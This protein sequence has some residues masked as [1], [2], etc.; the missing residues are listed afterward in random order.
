[1][2]ILKNNKNSKNNKNNEHPVITAPATGRQSS[3]AF[4]IFAAESSSLREESRIYYSL[5]QQ[6]PVIDAAITK[7]VRLTG[8]FGI[9]CD[10]SSWDKECDSLLKSIPVNGVSKGIYA[11]TDAFFEQL[12]TVGTA[13]GEIVTD[14]HGHP[15][16]LFNSPV[17][18]V[19]FKRAEN[20]FDVDI[21]VEDGVKETRAQNK[22]RILLGVL[23]PVPGKIT[24]QSLLKGL[25]FVSSILLKIY[26]TIG[27]NWERAGAVRYAVTYKPGA[28]PQ[29]KS[30]AGERAKQIAKS[31]G[32]AMKSGGD[33]KDFV[34]VGDVQIKVIGSDSAIL[35]PKVPVQQMLE[36]IIAKTGL[37]PFMLGFSWSTTERMSS[38]QADVLT[39][40]I[41]GY[42]RILTPVIEK[43]VRAF[44]ADL[45]YSGKL[46]VQWDDITLLD[47]VEQAKAELY[48][49]QAEKC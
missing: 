1:M 20:G 40:E 22:D 19:S 2:A 14:R 3:K 16:G 39:S 31:F 7:L 21:F 34:A 4:G 38:Q 11:F 6:V 18:S 33:I 17:D 45:G 37:P 29:D 41:E 44:M 28:D 5:R 12:L 49:R 36:Q 8:G 46:T 23:N 27:E 48:R 9:K 32:E 35:D 10:T 43:I 25:P 13:V 26:E 24:G 42:R 47:E 15:V 30:L